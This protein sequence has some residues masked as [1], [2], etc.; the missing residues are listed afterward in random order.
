V[1]WIRLGNTRRSALLSHLERVWPQLEAALQ[2]SEQL[3]EIA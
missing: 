2:R 3:I 1:V